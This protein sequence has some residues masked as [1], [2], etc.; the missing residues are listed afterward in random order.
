VTNEHAG[1]VAE[2]TSR[3]FGSGQKVF[4]RYTLVRVL[5]RGG[6]GIVWLARDEELER[7]VALKFL[8]DLMIKDHAVFDQL[9]RE[10]KRCL[11]LTHPHIVRIHD[12]VHDERSGCISME[13]IDGETLSNLRAEKVQRVF[14][15]DETATWMSQ[16]CDA[17]DYA[18]NHAKIIH[19]DLKP[20]NLMVNQR[21]ELKVSDFGI[22]RSLG[23]SASRLTLEQGRSGT[24]VYMSPQQLNGERCTHLDDIYSLGASIYEL[25]TSKPPFYS[26]NIDRQIC[27]R[28][29]PSMMER[30]KDLDIEPAL[31]PQIWEDTVAACLAKDPSQRPQSAAEVAQRL[32]LTSRQITTRVAPGKRL[33][34][35]ALVIGGIAA[36]SI[37]ALASF[38]FG[39]LTRPKPVSQPGISEKSIAVLPFENLSADQENAFF[40]DGVQDEILTDLAKIADLKVISRTSVMQYKNAATRNLREIAQQLGVSRILEG[41]VQRAGNRVRVSAQLIDAKTDTHLWAERYDRDLADVFAIQSEIAKAIAD[42]LQAK[43]SPTERAAIEQPPTRDV[44]AFELYSRAKTLMLSSSFSARTKDIQLQAID[45]LNRAVARDPQFFLAYCQLARAHDILY[46]INLDHTAARLA[47]AETA[48]EKAVHLRPNAGETHLLLA[49]HFYRGYLD[50]DHALNE[51]EIARR[52]LPNDPLILELTGYIKRRQGHWEESTRSFEREIDLDPRNLYIRQQIALSYQALRKYP[53]MAAVLDRALT[54]SPGDV[55]TRV[56]RA[57]IDLDWHADARPLHKTIAAILAENPTAAATLADAWVHLALCQRDVAGAERAIQALSDNAY[58]VD[59]VILSRS[60]IQGLVARV[61]GDTAAA[62]SA[63]TAAHAQ[64]LQLV[65]AQPDYGPAICMLGLIDAALGRKDEALREGR[66]AIE[67]LPVTSDALNGPHMVEFFAIICAW[68][69]EKDLAFQQLE[70]AVQLP[71]WISY[72]HL[73]LYPAWDLLRTD[74]RFEKIVASLTPNA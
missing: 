44:S 16:L 53:E 51:I 38:Y 43:I 54:I 27:E 59:A 66:R 49:E 18:H 41:S 20:A 61:R 28:V 57:Q 39:V 69:G 72:G 2:A 45:L 11:E 46:L 52:T 25:L 58:R 62:E 24:L 60:F 5:G 32:Q 64:Q 7:D 48:V 14:E 13:Y 40:A 73:R 31:V 37:L 34:S 1:G 4:G 63:F 47:L 21:G 9:K 74:P 35:K 67:L 50:Y 70:L 19:C 55:D 22:A 8:P 29:A 23:D 26:G 12:F 65:A 71:G 30:R 68:V 33:N 15:P 42:Q 17:L 10:T 6:M 3:E 36:L 56:A